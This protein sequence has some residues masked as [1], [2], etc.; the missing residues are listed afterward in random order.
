MKP[1][2]PAARSARSFEKPNSHPSISSIRPSSR[3]SEPACREA[4][5]A[6]AAFR[7]TFHA[8]QIESAA[9]SRRRRPF[10]QSRRHAQERIEGR[11]KS[12]AESMSEKELEKMASTQRKGKP[13]HVGG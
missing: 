7:E 5:S 6:R 9:K 10:L 11:V 12:M 13:E 1:I 2:S 4:G 8:C 3:V